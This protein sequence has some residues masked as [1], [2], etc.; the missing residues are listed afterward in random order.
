MANH[1]KTSQSVA[2]GVRGYFNGNCQAMLQSFL[3]AL[4]W[5]GSLWNTL[6]IAI[7]IVKQMLTDV[8]KKDL[9]L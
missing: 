5:G 7:A 2:F 6:A 8:S 4:Q 1:E 3:I 9:V